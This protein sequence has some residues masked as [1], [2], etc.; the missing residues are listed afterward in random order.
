MVID[1]HAHLFPESICAGRQCYCESE[2]AF[3]LL[4]RSPASRLVSAPELLAAMD[5]HGVDTS[6]VFGFP[7]QNPELFKLHNDYIMEDSGVSTPAAARPPR[8]RSAA[9]PA[10]FPGSGSLPSI[11]PGSM[12]MRSIAWRRS[13]TSA[14][15]GAGR[16]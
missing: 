15:T 1:F 2:P 6:V 8:R 12:T 14:A 4:Y 13:W 10:G 3:E 9:L 11:A 7:W 16:S 5:A